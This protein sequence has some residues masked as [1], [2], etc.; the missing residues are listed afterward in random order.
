[1]DGVFDKL[2]NSIRIE[3]LRTKDERIKKRRVDCA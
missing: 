3:I 2:K 1:M